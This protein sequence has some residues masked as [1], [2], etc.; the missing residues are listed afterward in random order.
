MTLAT[1]FGRRV[2]GVFATRIVRFVVGFGTSFLLARVLL[3]EGRGQYALLVLVPGMLMALGQLGL[4]SAMS[5]FAGRG[6]SV[7]DLQ[8]LGWLLTVAI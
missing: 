7:A 3:P 5:F 8:R 4:P 1:P 6:R 2:A